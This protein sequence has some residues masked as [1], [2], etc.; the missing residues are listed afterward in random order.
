V[1]ADTIAQDT[2]HEFNKAA[3]KILRGISESGLAEIGVAIGDA[4]SGK[5]LDNALSEFSKILGEGLISIGKELILASG[6]IKGIKVALD[7]L[8][9]N[10]LIGIAVGI[11]AIA[12]GEV[13]KNSV[14]HV[15]AH[16]FA[17]GGIV[18]GPTLGLVGEAG[19]EV[20]FPLDRLNRFIQGTRGAAGQNVSGTFRIQGRD[21]AL[22][23]GRDNKNNNLV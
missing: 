14:K 20:I 11:G 23:L 21:L 17:T 15:G 12:I 8:F 1:D 10:P 3:T 2:L 9:E 6:I 19:P 18:T 4:F 13:L 5:G 16:A 22:V 7:N